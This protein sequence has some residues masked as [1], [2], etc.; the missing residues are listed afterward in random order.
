VG[1][2]AVNAAARSYNDAETAEELRTGTIL[3]MISDVMSVV[4]AV[5]AIVVVRRAS[6]RLDA[7]ATAVPPPAPPA[8]EGDFTAPERPAGAPA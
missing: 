7:R 4:G 5:L 2:F 1:N 3:F 6:D 8:P